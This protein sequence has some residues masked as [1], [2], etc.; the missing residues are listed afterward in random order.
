V[1]RR[2]PRPR[3]SCPLHVGWCVFDCVGQLI[4]DTHTYAHLLCTSADETAFILVAML[5]VDA[6][7][8]RDLETFSEVLF[9]DTVK[10]PTL[11]KLGHAL[12]HRNAEKTTKKTQKFLQAFTYMPNMCH[13]MHQCSRFGLHHYLVIGTSLWSLEH[14]GS[15]LLMAARKSRATV[16]CSRAGRSIKASLCTINTATSWESARQIS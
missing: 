8:A 4:L 5:S 14:K 3:D 13:I 6:R 2:R 9:S 7:T 1:Y 15:N 16:D 12:Q 10:C 11:H